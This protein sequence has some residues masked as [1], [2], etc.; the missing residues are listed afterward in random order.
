[1]QIFGSV[2]EIFVIDVDYQFNTGRRVVYELYVN[3]CRPELC[4]S[5]TSIHIKIGFSGFAFKLSLLIKIDDMLDKV[6]IK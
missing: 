3:N 2:F 5:L 1:M 6:C 4:C